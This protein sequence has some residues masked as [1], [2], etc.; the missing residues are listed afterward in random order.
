MI[1]CVVQK[2]IATQWRRGNNTR[3]RWKFSHSSGACRYRLVAPRLA[4][5]CDNAG[6]WRWA[7][8]TLYTVT[9]LDHGCYWKQNNDHRPVTGARKNFNLKINIKAHRRRPKNLH[10]GDV[11]K[12]TVGSTDI[13][14][15]LESLHEI[16]PK[17]KMKYIWTLYAMCKRVYTRV[18][19]QFLSSMD[20]KKSRVYDDNNDLRLHHNA[21][22]NGSLL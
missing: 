12:N 17:S 18:T 19:C 5:S 15:W 7:Y 1:V 6:A 2:L 13:L 16:R 20:K 9:Q 11:I 22:N 10:P 21:Y 4:R 14:F 3:S 8:N